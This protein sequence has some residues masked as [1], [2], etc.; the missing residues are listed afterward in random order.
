MNFIPTSLPSVVVVEPRVFRDPRGYFLETWNSDRYA[1]AGLATT[2]IQDNMSV[3][4]PGVLRGLH[5]QWPTSQTKLVSVLAGAIFDVA[6]DVRVGSPTF[7][8]WVGEE[9]S[10]EGH[11]QLFIPAGFAH[12]FVVTS[13]SPATVSYKVDAPYTPGDELTVAWDDPDIAIE[14]PVS[15]PALS[16]KDR[17]GLRLR[18]IPTDRLP[19]YTA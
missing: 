18:D 19:V 7:G 15:G 5:L 14:W 10:T 17:E 11:R 16:G 2:F 12:G 3:S 4:H 13:T 1:V 8:R 9:L 6:V